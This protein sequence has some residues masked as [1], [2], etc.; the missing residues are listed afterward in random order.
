MYGFTETYRSALRTFSP[1]F[2]PS[3]KMRITRFE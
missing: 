2:L 3:T 1:I